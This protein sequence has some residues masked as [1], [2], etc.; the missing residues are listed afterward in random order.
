MKV[1]RNQR[2]VNKV[3]IL[4]GFGWRRLMILSY[5]QE[6]WFQSKE[7]EEVTKNL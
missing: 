5:D 1:E 6:D 2:N 4:T 7:V 3:H